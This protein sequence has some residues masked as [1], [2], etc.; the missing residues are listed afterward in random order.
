[1]TEN[2][3]A[4]RRNLTDAGLTKEEAERCAKLLAAG[5]KGEVLRLIETYRKTL[6]CDLHRTQRKLDCLDYFVMVTEKT[7]KNKSGAVRP[8]PLLQTSAAV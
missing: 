8:S 5:R 6:L 1:M 2:E 3:T 7:A 4:I